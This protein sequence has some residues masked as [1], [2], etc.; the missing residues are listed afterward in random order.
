MILKRVLK[1]SQGRHCID[2]CDKGATKH[3]LGS[4]VIFVVALLHYISRYQTLVLK[5]RISPYLIF[6]YVTSLSLRLLNE[7]YVTLHL[8]HSGY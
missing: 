7:R 8:C 1:S 6:C 2:F 3:S 5:G 4:D